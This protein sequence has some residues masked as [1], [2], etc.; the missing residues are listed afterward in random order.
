VAADNAMTG[1]KKIIVLNLAW[2]AGI[3]L[4]IFIVPDNTPFWLWVAIALATIAILNFLLYRRL[5][6]PLGAPRP[7]PLPTII[8]WICT[9]FC[10]LDVIFHLFHH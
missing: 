4:S 2:L 1:R 9:A 6:K 8:V 3:G 5:T 7:E 10:L